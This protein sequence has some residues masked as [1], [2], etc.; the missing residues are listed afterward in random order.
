MKYINNYILYNKRMSSIDDYILEKLKLSKDTNYRDIV[1]LYHENDICLRLIHYSDVVSCDLVLLDTINWDNQKC[2]FFPQDGSDEHIIF[3]RRYSYKFKK[4]N[5]YRY[6]SLT[7]QFGVDDE[8]ILIPMSES[9]EFL[10]DLLK[11]GTI[12]FNKLLNS[13]GEEFDIIVRFTHNSDYKKVFP[14]WIE[15]IKNRIKKKESD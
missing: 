12:N 11:K 1:D 6:I 14:K 2:W 3:S 5:K 10:E 15:Y 9:V 7:K 8:E 13:D 4:P